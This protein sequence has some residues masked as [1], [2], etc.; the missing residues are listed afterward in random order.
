MEEPSPILLRH[1]HLG[2]EVE[3][4]ISRSVQLQQAFPLPPSPMHMH[5][6]GLNYLT[7]QGN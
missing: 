5:T 2:V 4:P 1:S 6:T 3:Y 7:C